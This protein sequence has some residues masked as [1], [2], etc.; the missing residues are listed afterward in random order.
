MRFAAFVCVAV[1]W[2]SPLV[3]QEV[4]RS[5]PPRATARD[6]LFRDPVVARVLGTLVPGAGHI[7]ATEYRRGAQLYFGTV[8]MIGLGALVYI[9]DDCTFSFLDLKPCHAGPQWPHRTLGV[10][11][12]GVGAGTWVYS[13][14]DAPRA[15][16][17]ANER[18][19]SRHAFVSPVLEPRRG[20]KGGLNVGVA[21]EW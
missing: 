6:S 15:A 18:H 3:G 11:T 17:R 1:V 14:I 12:M 4:S 7:Y 5:E 8:S 21:L 19:Q 9:I 20:A 10:I 13:S 2:G 16:R